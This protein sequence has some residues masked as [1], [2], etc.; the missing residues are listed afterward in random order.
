MWAFYVN[1]GQG[2]ASFGKQNKDG[3]ILKFST[4]NVAYQQTPFTGFR[5]FLKA[6]RAGRKWNHMPFY[7]R[8]AG[9]GHLE[10]MTRDMFVGSSE[11]EIVE[12]ESDMGLQTNVLYFTATNESFPSLVRRVTFKNLDHDDALSLDILDGLGRLI[13]QGLI[14]AN[15]DSM[16]RTQEAW[17]RVYNTGESSESGHASITQ[18]FFHISQGTVDSAEVQVVNDGYFSIAFIENDVEGKEND[19]LPFVVDPNVVY[20]YDT[21]LTNPSAFFSS[22]FKD[23]LE[24]SQGTSSRT[25]CAFTGASLTIPPLGSV[26]ISAV[27]GYAQNLEQFVNEISPRLVAPGYVNSKREASR[28][29]VSDIV[30]KVETKSGLE[31]FDRYVEQVLHYF[32]Y[33]LL[34]HCLPTNHHTNSVR[35]CISL[36]LCYC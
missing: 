32:Y 14:E 5:T 16:G 29:L 8:T 7:P 36:T 22:S 26:T 34:L 9:E 27:Y 18:P 17:M 21:T 28:K 12:V 20:G 1:R 25:P 3:G 35:K 19:L 10:Q 30:E 4:A 31:I 15:L 2:I 6:T 24:S 23:V 11:M 33:N 13:P